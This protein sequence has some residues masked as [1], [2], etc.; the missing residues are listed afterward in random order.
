MPQRAVGEGVEGWNGFHLVPEDLPNPDA[1]GPEDEKVNGD[2]LEDI[3][4]LDLD[5]HLLPGLKLPLRRRERRTIRKQR[6]VEGWGVRRQERGGRKRNLVDLS[7]AS[8][9]DGLWRELRIDFLPRTG[10]PPL[11]LS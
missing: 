2:G 11:Q 10:E 1:N 9:C 7:Q 8:S 5:C 4:P 6:Q 3:G